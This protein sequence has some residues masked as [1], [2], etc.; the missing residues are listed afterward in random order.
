[1]AL[2]LIVLAA[3]TVLLGFFER[4]IEHFLTGADAHGGA[5]LPWAHRAA[6][7]LAL[8]GAALAW[9]EFGR[10]GAKQIGFVDRVPALQT[11]FAER[12]Y[13]DHLYRLMVD[14]LLDRGI[15]YLF[16]QNDN[17]VIDGTI[18]GMSRGTVESGRVAALLHQ[19]MIQ[20]RLLAV[21]AVIVFL[22]IYFFF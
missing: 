14:R 13:L 5:G 21:F 17:K 7:A 3:I 9:F 11:L 2:P 8:V 22:S 18:D 4:P 12:W 10:R 16:Y 6:L 20:Y 1:M 15:S 19:G